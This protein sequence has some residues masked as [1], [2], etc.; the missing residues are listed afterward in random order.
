MLSIFESKPLLS[1][2]DIEFLAATFKWQLKG[3]GGDD[4][5]N[6]IA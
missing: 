2:S 1:Q 3:F 5:Y 6:A 4:F